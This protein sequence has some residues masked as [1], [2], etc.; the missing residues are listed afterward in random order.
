MTLPLEK[1]QYVSETTTFVCTT[2]PLT[3]RKEHF[4]E[5]IFFILFVHWIT[6]TVYGIIYILRALDWCFLIQ[7]GIIFGHLRIYDL[8][9][10]GERASRYNLRL[11]GF[12]KNIKRVRINNLLYTIKKKKINTDQSYQVRSIAISID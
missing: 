2:F 7:I 11:T 4:N 5:K 6:A 10:R 9:F 3:K 12:L 8:C 1:E